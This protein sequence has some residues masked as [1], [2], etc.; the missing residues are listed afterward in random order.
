MNQEFIS[1]WKDGEW[2]FDSPKSNQNEVED[3]LMKKNLSAKC[4]ILPQ[5]ETPVQPRTRVL[6]QNQAPKKKPW[7]QEN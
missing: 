6:Q 4:V 5:G 1:V 2:W 7:T 3:M